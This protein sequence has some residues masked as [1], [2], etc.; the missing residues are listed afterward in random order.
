[1]AVHF[2]HNI[3][4]FKAD[5]CNLSPC[6]CYCFLCQLLDCTGCSDASQGKNLLGFLGLRTSR[7]IYEQEGISLLFSLAGL[8]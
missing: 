3:S 6:G 1:M 4:L 5:N 2:M 7:R 8:D